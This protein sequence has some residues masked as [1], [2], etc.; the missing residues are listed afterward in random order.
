MLDDSCRKTGG[1]KSFATADSAFQATSC[2][3]YYGGSSIS[4]SCAYSVSQHDGYYWIDYTF[5]TAI[6]NAGE[7]SIII[8]VVVNRNMQDVPFLSCGFNQTL[9]EMMIEM[10]GDTVKIEL[11]YS[12]SNAICVDAAGHLSL[13]EYLLRDFI[14]LCVP[15]KCFNLP[16]CWVYL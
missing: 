13:R 5:P 11:E 10:T 2:K 3:A 9:K 6:T 8:Y 4:Q 15:S 14:V 12:L 1:F 7:H 16:C